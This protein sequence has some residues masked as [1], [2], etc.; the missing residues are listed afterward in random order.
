MPAYPYQAFTPHKIEK[1]KKVFI[2][3]SKDDLEIVMSFIHSLQTLVL[4][5]TIETTLALHISSTR[6]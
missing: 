6:R 2:S 5:N 4:Q 3:Y 1:M